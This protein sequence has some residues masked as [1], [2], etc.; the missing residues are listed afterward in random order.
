M[1]APDPS[2]RLADQLINP[3][4]GIRAVTQE[5]DQIYSSAHKFEELDLSKELMMV[6]VRGRGGGGVRALKG[7]CASAGCVVLMWVCM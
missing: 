2:L 1:D 7:A 5:G 4:G 3:E 6:G